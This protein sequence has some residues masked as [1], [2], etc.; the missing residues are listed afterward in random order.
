MQFPVDWDPFFRDRLTLLDVFHYGTQH[1]RFAPAASHPRDQH[2]TP[3]TGQNKTPRSVTER[4]RRGSN[5]AAA[6]S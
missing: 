2:P 3:T 1:F 6:V 5:P 4:G